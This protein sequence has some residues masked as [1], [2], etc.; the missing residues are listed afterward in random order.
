MTRPLVRV[1]I[2]SKTRRRC[3]VQTNSLVEPEV[4][5]ALIRSTTNRVPA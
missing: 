2:V 1:I 3:A 5:L 4:F